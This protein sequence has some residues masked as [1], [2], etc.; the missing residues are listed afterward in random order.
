MTDSSSYETEINKTVNIDAPVSKVW[1]AMTNPALI[2]LWMS[3]SAIDVISDWQVGSPVI[4]RGGLHWISFENKGTIRQ[5]DPEKVFQ[6][7]YLSSLSNLPDI[8]ENYT[9]VRFVLTPIEDKT[10]VILTLS[11][12]PD[13]IIYKHVNFYW[14]VTLGIFKKLCEQL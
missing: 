5:L 1:N 12:F 13:E 9:E 2:K 6:Y 4:F 14:N 3:D 7:N 8:P 11:N 10:M